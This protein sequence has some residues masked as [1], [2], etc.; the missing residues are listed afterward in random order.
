MNRL[1]IHF[2]CL[3]MVL[4]AML[5]GSVTLSAQDGYYDDY[6][7]Y[8]HPPCQHSGDLQVW[9]ITKYRPGLASWDVPEQTRGRFCMS[10]T[11]VDIQCYQLTL[12]FCIEKLERVTPK[13]FR[14][15]RSNKD[16]IFD[17]MEVREAFGENRGTYQILIGKLDDDG[18]IQNTV[19]LIARPMQKLMPANRDGQPVVSQ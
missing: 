9:N 5:C 8:S 6:E 1:R 11:L 15:Y 14:I 7:Y 16:D 19:Q 18:N 17:Y 12:T 3:A 2:P 13:F 10:N 4:A